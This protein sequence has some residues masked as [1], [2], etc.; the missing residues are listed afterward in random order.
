[1]QAPC[2]P[3]HILGKKPVLKRYARAINFAKMLGV[4]KNG[5]PGEA[6]GSGEKR[7]NVSKGREEREKGKD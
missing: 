6:N 5:E 1:M 7:S 3:S 2:R 4:S